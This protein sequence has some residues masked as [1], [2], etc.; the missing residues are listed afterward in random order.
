MRTLPRFILVAAVLLGVSTGCYAQGGSKRD[1]LVP[2]IVCDT[3]GQ[4]E[5]IINELQEGYAPGK[6]RYPG[7]RHV[8]N[9]T[10]E[11]TCYSS[12]INLAAVTIG[13]KEREFA[14]VE[15]LPGKLY[16]VVIV[17]MTLVFGHTVY[18]TLS[19]FT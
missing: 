12:R 18:V 1:W 8:L 11:E 7:D 6:R 14:D 16:Q 13:R 9:E 17:E 2:S 10:G 15:M 3:V 4:L 5:D 19:V